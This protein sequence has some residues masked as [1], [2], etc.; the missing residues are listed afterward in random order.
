M[1]EIQDNK[2]TQ[3]SFME[4]LESN[5]PPISAPKSSLF[6]M[7]SA[8]Q[9]IMEAQNLPDP[10]PLYKTLLH[11]GELCCLFADSNLG[12]SIFAVQIANKI[13]KDT[14][15]IVNYFDFELSLKQ[16]QK[17]YTG[18]FGEL[19]TF[20]PNLNRIEMDF[21]ELGFGEDYEIAIKE[22]LWDNIRESGAKVIIIDNITWLE[23]NAEDPKLAGRLMQELVRIKR[24][25]GVT[26]LV[27]GHTPKRDL[28]T[29][30]TQ[31][32]LAG[33][34]RLFNFM[35]S[36][37]AIG[38]SIRGESVRYVKQLKTRM[39]KVEY[40]ENN[41]I[42]YEITKEGSFLFLKETGYSSEKDHLGKSKGEIMEQKKKE[43]MELFNENPS[44]SDRAIG[45]MTGLGKS[46]VNR[47]LKPLREE[48]AMEL[49]NGNPSLSNEE[50]RESTGLKP[51]AIEK[52]LKPLREKSETPE[53]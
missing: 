28:S 19:Y 52:L 37:F 35:D 30:L 2:V 43:A 17:R 44:L 38:K 21:C 4:G 31:N 7:K 49:F 34:K 6:K 48:K 53:E 12:K 9:W 25:L 32:S 8:N 1:A 41:V 22:G 45:E 33:S 10:Q 39:G 16:F 13:A 20:E 40:G 36:V 3:R 14:G 24:E 27:L 51:E 18:D 46:T 26:V 5:E 15:Y 47:L 23:N 29:P 42:C 11:E 50:I